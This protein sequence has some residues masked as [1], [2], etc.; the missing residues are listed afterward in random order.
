MQYQLATTD[1]HLRDIVVVL[2]LVNTGV[3]PQEDIY[4]SI[5]LKPDL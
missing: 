2:A 3:Y 5:D 4:L 1:L